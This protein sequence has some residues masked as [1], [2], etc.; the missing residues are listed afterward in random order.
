VAG[1]W[2]GTY[3]SCSIDI[4]G[5]S[6]IYAAAAS[7]SQDGSRVT[8][9]VTTQSAQLSESTLEGTLQ[10]NE[11]RGRLQVSGEWVQLTGSANA[12]QVTMT[13]RDG[14]ISQGTI[15]LSR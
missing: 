2:Q 13:F 9:R 6:P 11:L 4:I 5:C 1:S 7:L 14:L 10:D 3:Q 15:R 8:G 12:S